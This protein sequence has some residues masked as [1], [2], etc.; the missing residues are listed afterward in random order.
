MKKPPERPPDLI[1]QLGLHAAIGGAAGIAIASLLVLINAGGL[2]QLLLATG[3][4][5]VPLLII[6]ISFASLFATLQVSLAIMAAES[7][8]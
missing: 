2:K 1:Q 8:S 4:P 5:F 6:E 7:D 3:E